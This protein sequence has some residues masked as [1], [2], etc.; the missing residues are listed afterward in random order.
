[1]SINEL[2]PS[3]SMFRAAG[4]NASDTTSFRAVHDSVQFRLHMDIGAQ[5]AQHE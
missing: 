5:A 2:A 3:K 1:M 4:Y